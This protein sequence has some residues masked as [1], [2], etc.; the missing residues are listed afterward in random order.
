MRLCVLGFI[1]T[2]ETANSLEDHINHVIVSPPCVFV[3]AWVSLNVVL[4]WVAAFTMLCYF[5]HSLHTYTHTQDLAGHLEES[6]Q[7]ISSAV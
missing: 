2:G 1:F 6:K 3:C 5:I 4:P 7:N